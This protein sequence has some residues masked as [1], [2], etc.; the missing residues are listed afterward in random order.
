MIWGIFIYIILVLITSYTSMSNTSLGVAVSGLVCPL[1]ALF[2]G[3]G[4]RGSLYGD[5]KQK[6]AGIIFGILISSLSLFWI[7]SSGFYVII[8]DVT[9]K[10]ELWVILGLLIG[11]VF[12]LKKD[13][14]LE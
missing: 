8:Y 5:N 13:A 14:I 3:S 1:L 2:A 6:L 10:G 9:I 12:T 11:F 7:S 4:I